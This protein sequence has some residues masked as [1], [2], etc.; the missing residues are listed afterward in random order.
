[1]FTQRGLLIAGH[2]SV[3]PSRGPL[4]QFTPWAISRIIVAC[5][6]LTG[7][8]HEHAVAPS[9]WQLSPGLQAPAR[10]IAALRSSTDGLHPGTI[11]AAAATRIHAPN[12]RIDMCPSTSS[13][14]DRT[15]IRLR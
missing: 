15:R 2:C 14:P 12:E 4:G 11:V 13:G 8:A 5:D 7:W 6:E 10:V 3:P 9:S 1:M